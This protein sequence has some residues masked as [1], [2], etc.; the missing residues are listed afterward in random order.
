MRN[1][2]TP[3]RHNQRT[4]VVGTNTGTHA[5]HHHESCEAKH[6]AQHAGW[7]SDDSGRCR[8][9]CPTA[10][11]SAHARVGIRVVVMTVCRGWAGK[12]VTASV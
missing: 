8:V 6:P 1:D 4:R 2:G 12:S 11:V 5:H 3:L 7:S 10:C 9:L